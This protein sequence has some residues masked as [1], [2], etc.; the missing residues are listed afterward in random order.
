[1]HSFLHSVVGS[2][3]SKSIGPGSVYCAFTLKAGLE[4]ID[5][6]SHRTRISHSHEMLS[7][8]ANVWKII[9]IMGW[10]KVDTTMR[11]FSVKDITALSS[12]V[13]SGDGAL[14]RKHWSNDCGGPI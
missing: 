12:V 7:G 5:V 10:N 13:L 11:Y 3:I 9:A 8:C 14:L 4:S 2:G 1:M 6:S